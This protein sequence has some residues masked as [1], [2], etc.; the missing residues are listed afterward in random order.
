MVR[1]PLEA[2]V[3]KKVNTL[4]IL[5]VHARDLVERFVQNAVFSTSS[6]EW[7][8]QL[9]FY[10]DVSI[11]NI[12]IRQCSGKFRYVNEFKVRAIEPRATWETIESSAS[13]VP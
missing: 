13:V 9:R 6:F 1:K 10:W 2:K 5:D 4:I 7:E 11:D 3:R 8:S 12:E